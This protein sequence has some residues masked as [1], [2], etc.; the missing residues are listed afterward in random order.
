GRLLRDTE[1]GLLP[2]GCASAVLLDRAA[3]GALTRIVFADAQ[4]EDR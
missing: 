4:G 2:R 3:A 1:A